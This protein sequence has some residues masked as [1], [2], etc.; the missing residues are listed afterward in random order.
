M[1]R[2][3]KIVLLAHCI[4]NVNAKVYGLAIEQ[5]GC[6][7]IVTGLLNSGFGIIQLPCV[8]QS[9]FGINRW[10]QVKNQLNFSAFRIKCRSL[11]QPIIEQVLDFYENG[12]EIVSV[13]GIDGSPTCGVNY[14]CTGN[15]GG[16]IGE[17]YDL[18]AKIASLSTMHE[19]GVMMK[20]LQQMLEEEGIAVK[21][22]AIDENNPYTAGEELISKLVD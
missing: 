20:I 3:K 21:F 1:K 16:E 19:Q 17:G 2:N 15:W 4:L 12:Y 14:T 8:E 9:C 6:K 11:L 22:M 5:A 7:Q 18:P 13:I 10:G